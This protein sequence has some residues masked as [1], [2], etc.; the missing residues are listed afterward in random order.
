MEILLGILILAIFVVVGHKISYRIVIMQLDKAI[1]ETGLVEKVNKEGIMSLETYM[2]IN[3]YLAKNYGYTYN[4]AFD[5]IMV[6]ADLRKYK[7]NKYNMNE[8]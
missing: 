5:M 3:K 7:N 1:T 6:M 4:N 2:T 8:N